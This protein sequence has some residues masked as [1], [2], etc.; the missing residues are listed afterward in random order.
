MSK[1][2]LGA[3]IVLAVEGNQLITTAVRFF[4]GKHPVPEVK[5]RDWAETGKSLSGRRFWLTQIAHKVY[6]L[7]V[8]G[9]RLLGLYHFRHLLCGRNANP[10]ATFNRDLSCRGAFRLY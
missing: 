2:L 6:K 4:F 7:C 8:L 3:T 9:K 5:I 10:I 1:G